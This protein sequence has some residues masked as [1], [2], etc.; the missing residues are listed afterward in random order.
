METVADRI[1]RL[2]DICCD[3]NRSEFARRIGLTPAY[4]SKIDKER[5]RTP[6]DRT[7]ADI[8]REF[9]VN[10]HWLE[11][12]EGEMFNNLDKEREIALFFRQVSG[13]PDTELDQ[14]RQNLVMALAKLDES[15][16]ETV[17]RIIKKLSGNE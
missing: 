12:G 6:S 1:I 8:C 7:L 13:H 2:V 3:G 11:T 4:I 17:L 14:F 15:E 9:N 10:R 16:W 5:D